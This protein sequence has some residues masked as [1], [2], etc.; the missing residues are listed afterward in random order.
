MLY[1]YVFRVTD[2]E[3]GEILLDTKPYVSTPDDITPKLNT[4]RK[5][6]LNNQ[7]R[8]RLLCFEIICTRFKPKKELDL[9]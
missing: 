3:T 9:F 5:F 1:S 6:F 7:K 4:Y 2:V 8:G